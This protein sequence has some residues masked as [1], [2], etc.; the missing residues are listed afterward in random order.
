VTQVVPA[1]AGAD[2]WV[3]LYRVLVRHH[4]VE[5]RANLPDTALRE[6]LDVPGAILFRADADGELA[7]MVLW[8]R[9]DDR[10]YY[11]LGAYNEIGYRTRAAYALF[12]VSLREFR[13]HADHAAL[14][15]G[16]GVDVP[17]GDDGL[18]RFKRGWG[19]I[20]RPAFL[21]GRVLDPDAYGRLSPRGEISTAYFPAYRAPGDEPS[22]PEASDA[23]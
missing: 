19:T 20:E 9:S 12:D 3:G 14:G 6:Q 4:G 8:M 5:G 11:H 7:G 17:D 21:G 15:S 10:V 23:R 2:E 1:R 16:A 22:D 13:G 18:V